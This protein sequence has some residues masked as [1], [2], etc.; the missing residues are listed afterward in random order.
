MPDIIV[1]NQSE[2]DAALKNAKGGE[3]IKLAAGTYTSLTVANRNF[4]SNV[5]IT[6]LDRANKANVTKLA[7]S[8]TSNLTVLNLDVKTTLTS[9]V[10][11][12]FIYD[13]N[14]VVLD[15]VA[16]SGGT[17]DPSQALGLGLQVR[18]ATNITMRNS[19]IDHF[20]VGLGGQNIDGLVLQNNS[21]HDNRRDHTNFNEIS[22]AKIDGNTFTN[23]FPVGD[24]HPDAIQFW[25]ANSVKANTN[26]SITNNV[27]MQGAGGPSQG[28]FLGG[29]NPAL[30]Y[31]NINISNNLVYVSGWSH[32]I[33]VNSGTNIVV[34]SNTVVSKVD[35]TDYWIMLN[36][37]NGAKVTNNVTDNIVVT[38]SS[39]N[40]DLGKNILL[41]Q[42]ASAIRSIAGLNAVHTARLADLLLP[43]IGYQPPAG[44]AAAALVKS[45]LQVAQPIPSS[46]LLD[47]NFKNGGLIDLSS[48]NSAK[49]MAAIDASAVS[50]DSFHIKTGVG[51][52]LDKGTSRQIYG[53]SAFTLNFDLKR[54][55]TTAPVGDIMSIYRS[56][57]V[58]LRADGELNFT[59]TNSAGQTYTVLTKG[60]KLTDTANHKIAVTYDSSRNKATIYVD[61]VERGSGLVT[62][63]TRQPESWG[64]YIGGSYGRTTVSGTI[65][66]IEI[67]DTPLSAVQVQS[68]GAASSAA[69][70]DALK[71]NL[72][73]GAASTATSLLTGG[74]SQTPVSTGTLA[75]SN[76]LTG[77]TGQL[78]QLQQVLADKT[79]LGAGAMPSNSLNTFM[80]SQIQALLTNHA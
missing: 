33:A 76:T 38:K 51:F 70:A 62:G 30:K 16:I 37:V 18:N 11:Q 7:I 69:T 19:S 35:N 34:D 55:S 8:K 61:G 75:G 67:R 24:E 20:I 79:L 29:E 57:G 15:G 58:S 71:N 54:D 10:K 28:I 23:L 73:N 9:D 80:V 50:G 21:F 47:L 59:M 53:L 46:L 68:L 1:R 44:S 78:T 27:I 14:K 17:G 72:A 49:T 42:D 40:V 26:I 39:A 4:A 43:G 48:W 77:A 6:S 45:Q 36:D 64:L 22:N 63:T 74:T 32:G 5:T 60:A 41:N 3:T 13:S 25:T 31:D 66:N 56:W 12:N 2:L 65:G 52:S